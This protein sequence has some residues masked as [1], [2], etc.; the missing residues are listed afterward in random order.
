M[1]R[2]WCGEY[3]GGCEDGGNV[4]ATEAMKIGGGAGASAIIV[5]IVNEIFGYFE[6]AQISAQHQAGAESY[7]MLIETLAENCK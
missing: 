5:Q 6:A 7:L 3:A 1:L 4:M 2:G